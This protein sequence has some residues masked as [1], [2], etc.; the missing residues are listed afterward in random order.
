MSCP[1]QPAH[2]QCVE[3]HPGLLAY[4]NDPIAFLAALKTASTIRQA[5]LEAVP[6][7]ERPN[8]YRGDQRQPWHPRPARL[9]KAA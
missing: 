6:V 1:N 7:P 4:A 8:N 2:C 9:R 3:H 5:R